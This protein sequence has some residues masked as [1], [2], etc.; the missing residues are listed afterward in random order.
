MPKLAHFPIGTRFGRLVMAGFGTNKHGRIRQLANCDCG[1]TGVVIQAPSAVIH[2]V[3][4]SCGC[5]QR[6]KRSAGN[7]IHGQ[8][9]TPEYK[10]WAA[11][12]D[13]CYN[14]SNNNYERYGG[15]GIRVCERWLNSA[16]NFLMDMGKRPSPKHSIERLDNDSDYGP[17]NCIWADKKQQA[18]NTRQNRIVVF[19][20]QEMSLAEAVERSATAKYATVHARLRKG[21]S[22]EQALDARDWRIEK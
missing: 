1:K 19:R 14:P 3:H 18:R 5:L 8:V 13:R 16:E 15:R 12:K 4:K 11:I 22:L 2:G 9:G 21:F 20:G 7:P 17:G 10:A 6:E